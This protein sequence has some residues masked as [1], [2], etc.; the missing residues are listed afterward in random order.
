MP[1]RASTHAALAPTL[2]PLAGNR[3]VQEVVLVLAGTALIAIA[4]KI[5]VPFVPVP[6][7]L[8]TLAIMLIAATY[9][10]RL[11]TLTVIAYLGEGLLGLPVFTN[12]PP[13]VAGPLYFLGPTGGFLLGF[14]ALAMIVGHAAD[15]GFDRSAIRLFAAILAGEVAMFALGFVWLAWFATLSSGAVGLGTEQALAA[16]VIPFIWGD[17]LKSALAA[18][19]VP[20]AWSLVRP[21]DR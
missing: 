2:L 10:F 13:L 17:L 3:T 20:A 18:F 12:T 16:G 5:K 6:M 9:G 11:G 15:R 19:L 1:S 14:V 8:Q 21:A 7:T 4:A